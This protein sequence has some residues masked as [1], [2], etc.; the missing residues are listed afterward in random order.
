MHLEG[1]GNAPGPG[2]ALNTRVGMETTLTLLVDDAGH[3]WYFFA[4][5]SRQCLQK[6]RDACGQQPPLFSSH[7]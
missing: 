2:C 7:P 4:N 6:T 1:V 5:G 3:R